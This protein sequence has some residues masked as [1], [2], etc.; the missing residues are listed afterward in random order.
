MDVVLVLLAVS[1]ILFF[2]FFAEFI[3]RIIGTVAFVLFIAGGFVM[4]TSFGNAEKF[5]KGRDILI[6]ATVGLIIAF[7]A[8]F[9]VRE[10]LDI[11]GVANE[12]RGL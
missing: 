3:F 7:S 1:L 11:L 8:F 9:L 5:K 10:L 6:A 4:I 2:G 12:F